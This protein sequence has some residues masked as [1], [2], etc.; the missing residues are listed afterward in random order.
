MS[1]LTT[2]KNFRVEDITHKPKQEPTRIR[3]FEKVSRGRF[4]KNDF[5][6]LLPLRGSIKSAGYDFF[7]PHDVEIEPN[8]QITIWTDIKAYM[9]DGEYLAL[10]PRSS[11][12]I[13]L[14]L[15]LANT[16]GI[17]DSDYYNN[18]NNEG[19]IGICIRNCGEKSVNLSRGDRIAQGIFQPFLVSDNCNSG[20]ERKGGIG[21]TGE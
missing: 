11:V 18:E 6:P 19:N 3:G 17:I 20:E 16:V 15:R 1:E 21:S 12:G 10:Y 4:R 14:E 13:K 9:K 8:K 7:V 2:T 5:E